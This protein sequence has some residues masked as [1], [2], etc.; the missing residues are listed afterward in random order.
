MTNTDFFDDDLLQQRDSAKRIKMGP[1]D[2][3]S[4]ELPQSPV[5]NLNLTGIGR[6][7][8]DIEARSAEAQDQLERLQQRQTELERERRN[9]E[10]IREKHFEYEDGKRDM[11]DHLRKSLTKLERDQIRTEQV[12]ELLRTTRERFKILL[13]DIDNLAEDAWEQD[14]IREELGAALAM[15]EDS[16]LE[17]NKSMAKIQAISDEKQRDA[18]GSDAIYEEHYS[19][20]AMMDEQP[21]SFWLKVGMAISLPLIVALVVIAFIA[22]FLQGQGII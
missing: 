9:L 22:F 11:L 20:P 21:F 7:R 15:L 2:E 16:R 14:S 5:S 19:R 10:D 13:S 8:E 12:A 17:Y 18:V 1:A 3:H 6:H 4:V